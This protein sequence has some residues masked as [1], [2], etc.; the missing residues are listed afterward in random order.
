[1]KG[2]SVMGINPKYG[3]FSYKAKVIYK[4]KWI[5]TPEFEFQLPS[6]RAKGLQGRALERFLAMDEIFSPT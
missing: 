4:R 3:R 1:M 5:R 6:L 2:K